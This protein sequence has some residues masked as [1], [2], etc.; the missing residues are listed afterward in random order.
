M[1]E[2]K[3]NI[4]VMCCDQF[5]NTSNYQRRAGGHIL[6][7]PRDKNELFRFLEHVNDKHYITFVHTESKLC[8]Y[9]EKSHLLQPSKAQCSLYVPPV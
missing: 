4:L 8:N 9:K 5:C 2:K 3:A 1:S 6:W 7:I